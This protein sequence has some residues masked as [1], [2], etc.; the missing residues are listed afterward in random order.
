[1]LKNLETVSRDQ[2]ASLISMVSGE[3]KVDLPE[4][5]RWIER[6][7]THEA[8]D[9]QYDL[10]QDTFSGAFKVATRY[11]ARLAALFITAATPLTVLS[12]LVS[13]NHCFFYLSFRQSLQGAQ[14]VSKQ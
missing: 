6:N 8:N 14:Q 2:L 7:T 12:P 9:P 4:T 3:P 11:T 10:H 5:L 1:M 13:D